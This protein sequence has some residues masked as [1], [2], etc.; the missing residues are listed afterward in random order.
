MKPL[1]PCTLR[2]SGDGR[3]GRAPIAGHRRGG[4]TAVLRKP[5]MQR[6]QVK[7]LMRLE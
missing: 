4:D 3:Q 6:K 1:S 5:I 7:G 2:Q